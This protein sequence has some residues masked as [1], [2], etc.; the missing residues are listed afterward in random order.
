MAEGPRLS[1][2][3]SAWTAAGSVPGPCRKRQL[4]PMVSATL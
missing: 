1:R 3:R 4:R 2:P